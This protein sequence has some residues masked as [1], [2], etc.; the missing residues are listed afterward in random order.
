MELSLA[1][2]TAFVTGGNIGIGR[3]VS[4]AL[5]RCGADVALTYFSHEAEGKETVDAIKAMGRNPK[6]PKPRRYD[7]I[8][9]M[10]FI[11]VHSFFS[12]FLADF[13]IIPSALSNP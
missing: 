12:V 8:C 13:L 9:S 5:A 10:D 2:K 3:A 1:G 7:Y 4:L 11:S 6:T